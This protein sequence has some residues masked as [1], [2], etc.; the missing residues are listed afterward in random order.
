M[1]NGALA[2]P[3]LKRSPSLMSRMASKWLCGGQS[4]QVLEDNFVPAKPARECVPHPVHLQQCSDGSKAVTMR[5][6]LGCRWHACLPWHQHPLPGK[7]SSAAQGG[8][9]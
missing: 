7:A 5:S 2:K 9:A 4:P 6:A 3:H 8:A 1:G